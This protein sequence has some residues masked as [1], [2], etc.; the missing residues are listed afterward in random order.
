MNSI[1]EGEQCSPF[2]QLC[3]NENISVVWLNREYGI[4]RQQEKS[5]S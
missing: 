4:K 5:R 2:F 1:D 3:M